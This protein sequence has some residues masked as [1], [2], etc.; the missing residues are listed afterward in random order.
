MGGT[1]GHR[2]FSV[3]GRALLGR[4]QNYTKAEFALAADKWI[5]ALQRIVLARLK[6]VSTT[7]AFF[8]GSDM[9]DRKD[10]HVLVVQVMKDQPSIRML[11][12]APRIPSAQRKTHEEAT[13]AEGFPKYE[14][15]QDDGRGRPVAAGKR[16]CYYPLLLVE[17]LARNRDWM[18]AD[19]GAEGASRTAM[20][21]AIATGAP[22]TILLPS[23][24]D[25]QGDHDLLCVLEPARYESAATAV[26]KRP[27]QQPE[28]D[29][30]VLGVIS[31]DTM[32]ETALNRPPLGIDIC[33]SAPS[34]ENKTVP[35]YTRRAPPP[36]PGGIWQ[37]LK[38]IATPSLGEVRELG[39]VQVAD[40]QW[41]VECFPT[42]A[43]IA[44]Y[45][46]RKPAIA[47]LVGL[48]ITG[49]LVGYL[50]LLTG[51]PPAWN[52]WLPSDGA[53]SREPTLYPPPDRQYGR[54][55]LPARRAREN[56]GCQQARV[57]RP[58]VRA[59]NCCR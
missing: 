4:E 10:F 9:N 20:Q 40:S 12:W 31:V 50:W 16:D 11:A 32:V 37:R 51:A 38:A 1:D 52:K 55:L 44:E 54:R 33:I 58:G 34:S 30:F 59:R 56:P 39:S 8:R 35:V 28:L 14:I 23:S 24:A 19:L 22:V 29:G 3:L 36:A 15:R 47:V 57:R 2:L 49:L 18:G 53:T 13:R 27:P 41:T 45:H 17:P 46:T 48:L 42:A 21:R 43:Y 26:M 6:S 7:A 5:Q 25:K